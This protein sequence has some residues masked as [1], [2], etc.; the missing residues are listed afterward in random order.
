MPH[1]GAPGSLSATYLGEWLRR[2]M[3]EVVDARS[4]LRAAH[5]MFGSMVRGGFSESPH[6]ASWWHRREKCAS[7]KDDSAMSSHLIGAIASLHGAENEPRSGARS[8]HQPTHRGVASAEVFSVQ[9][10][11]DHSLKGGCTTPSC[12]DRAA[13]PA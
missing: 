12:R 4:K 2:E 13:A 1:G 6:V 3:S 8:V 11:G 9:R 10:A 5:G 7:A